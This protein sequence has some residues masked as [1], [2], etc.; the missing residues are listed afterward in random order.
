MTE[1]RKRCEGQGC[2]LCV[3]AGDYA[4]EYEDEYDRG[5]WMDPPPATEGR[6]NV[7]NRC[8]GKIESK[9]WDNYTYDP[10]TGEVKPGKSP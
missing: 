2:P 8:L 10:Q 6:R 1:P 4:P 5:A 9:T 7:C 3:L